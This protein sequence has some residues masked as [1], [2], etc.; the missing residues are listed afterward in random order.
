MISIC[1]DSTNMVHRNRNSQRQPSLLWYLVGL[2]FI[3]AFSLLFP[4]SWSWHTPELDR[5]PHEGVENN[6]FFDLDL[7]LQRAPLIPARSLTAIFPLTLQAMPFLGDI[8]QPLLTPSPYLFEIV[9]VCPASTISEARTMLRKLDPSISDYP[10]IR[11]YPL[12]GRLD[13]DLGV[14]DAASQV[15]TG[16]V[17]VMNEHGLLQTSNFS[18]ALLLHPLVIP[19]PIGPKGV[20]VSAS[21]SS[22]I[23]PSA[24]PQ[25][26]SYLYPPFVM[27]T[28]LTMKSQS[29]SDDPWAALG[30]H[31]SESRSDGHGGIVIGLEN[32]DSAW[33]SASRHSAVSP[34]HH[35]YVRNEKLFSFHNQYSTLLSHT[36]PPNLPS[37]SFTFGTFAI[38]LPAL[39]DLRAFSTFVCLLKT[40]NH[41]VNVLIYEELDSASNRQ[42]WDDRHLLVEGCRLTY[43]VSLSHP[44]SHPH[45]SRHTAS[46]WVKTFGRQPDIVLGLSEEAQFIGLSGFSRS[47]DFYELILIP[48]SDLPH[49]SWMFSL[50]LAEWQ[51]SVL[52]ATLRLIISLLYL[53][54]IGMPFASTSVS[55]RKTDHSP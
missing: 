11:L 20:S 17:L 38:F 36:N 49:C 6:N 54:Q 27:P 29:A 47:N 22:C 13:L 41:D 5:N 55:S 43:S 45:F 35:Q 30:Y 31:I 1:T 34:V 4:T 28:S 23:I 9:I 10:D 19:V 37:T 2:S 7:E 50:S 14:I 33:C 16:W 8:L 21:N 51:S 52:L 40:R 42:G 32:L 44:L 12:V 3:L 46:N 26:A 48:R 25:R 53:C 39:Q 18:Q 24:V 15:S